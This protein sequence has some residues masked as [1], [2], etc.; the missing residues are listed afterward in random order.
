MKQCPDKLL[1]GLVRNVSVPIYSST[2]YGPAVGTQ[3]ERDALWGALDISPGTIAL[4]DDFAAQNGLPR[5]QRF[6]WDKSK[7]TYIIGAFHQMH[8]LVRFHSHP[9]CLRE[10]ISNHQFADQNPKIH[11]RGPPRRPTRRPPLSSRRALSR[12]PPTRRLLPRRRHPLVRTPAQ[13]LPR[14]L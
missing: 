12:Q 2:E 9:P 10:R 3:E 8:C 11:I 5:S 13:T 1:A 7:G 4:S 6:P 14:R